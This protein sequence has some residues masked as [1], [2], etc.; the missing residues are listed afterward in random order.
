MSDLKRT[1]WWI[2]GDWCGVLGKKLKSG[3]LMQMGCV[4]I[5]NSRFAACSWQILRSIG[6]R[7]DSHWTFFSNRQTYKSW[8]KDGLLLN[9][10]VREFSILILSSE[11]KSNAKR[12]IVTQSNAMMRLPKVRRCSFVTARQS[13]HLASSSSTS[14]RKRYAITQHLR[15]RSREKRHSFFYQANGCYRVWLI[16][17]YPLKYILL[18]SLWW[19]TWFWAT[20][21]HEIIIQILRCVYFIYFIYHLSRNYK[22]W[23]DFIRFPKVRV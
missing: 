19:G 2:L 16:A 5:I 17:L 6:L 9:Q 3:K 21:I 4:A 12:A 11:K 23:G 18:F 15:E 22:I 8:H 10:S 20:M 14:L 13:A 1:S 7:T